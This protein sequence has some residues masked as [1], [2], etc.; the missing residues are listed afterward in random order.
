MQI[1]KKMI[2][3]IV[4]KVLKEQEEISDAPAEAPADAKTDRTQQK[5]GEANVRQVQV[6]V[7]QIKNRAKDPLNRMA[8]WAGDKQNKRLAVIRAFLVDP[9]IGGLDPAQIDSFLERLFQSLR[10]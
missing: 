4:S 8:K 10:A 6:F 1:S 3:E 9:E 5:S 2:T 7:D